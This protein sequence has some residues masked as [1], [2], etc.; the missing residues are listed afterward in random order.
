MQ[1]FLVIPAFSGILAYRES[2]GNAGIP[3]LSGI[4]NFL[5]MAH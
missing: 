4:A 3:A 2:L 5:R 1:E